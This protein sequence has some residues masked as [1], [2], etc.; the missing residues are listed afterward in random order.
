MCHWNTF[1]VKLELNNSLSAAPASAILIEE[2]SF[3]GIQWPIQTSPLWLE[4]DNKGFK[5]QRSY[6]VYRFCAMFPGLR[7]QKCCHCKAGQS[8]DIRKTG[9]FLIYFML[10]LHSLHMKCLLLLF[11]PLQLWRGVQVLHLSWDLRPEERAANAV[12]LLA[13]LF[14]VMLLTALFEKYFNYEK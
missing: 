13:D 2:A 11:L 10:Y 12:W 7:P 1:P 5:S 9:H 14:S 4:S 8:Q 3:R 6:R